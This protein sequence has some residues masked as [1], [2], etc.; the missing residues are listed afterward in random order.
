MRIWFMNVTPQKKIKLVTKMF[1]CRFKR[2]Y[3]LGLWVEIHAGVRRLG[4]KLGFLPS[5]IETKELRKLKLSA[6]S[7]N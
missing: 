7:S 6:D 2:H 3:F 4:K 1:D 5:H